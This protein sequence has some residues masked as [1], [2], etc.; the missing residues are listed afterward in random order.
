[1][2]TA[3][4]GQTK[5]GIHPFSHTGDAGFRLVAKTLPGVFILAAQA[6]YGVMT[7]RR[8]LRAR[9]R[10]E[11]AVEAPDTA[12]LLVGWLNELL[13]LFDTTG[14]MGK[15]IT[16]QELTPQ[17]LRAALRG[18]DLNPERHI[19]KTGVKAATY[20]HLSVTQTPSGW[21]ATIILDL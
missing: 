17:R 4:A 19:Y 7:D 13:F 14:F 9:D 20:H 16:I 3:G 1:M 21:E 12:S 11:V 8:R 2:D 6:L 5:Y 10:R 18:E 15:E